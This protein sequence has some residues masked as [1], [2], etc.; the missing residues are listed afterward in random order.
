MTRTFLVTGGAGFVG[1]HLTESL[2]ADGNHVIVLD[3]LSTGC[4]ENLRESLATG[5]VEFVEGDV[6]DAEVVE[7]C[8]REAEVCVHLAARLGVARIVR[9][10]LGSLREN[11]LGADIVMAAAARHG[12]RLLFSS[13]SEVSTGPG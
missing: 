6:L 9:Q 10:P 2:V 3:D 12:R 13:S 5:R 4:R 11:V 7:S 8:M 1:S